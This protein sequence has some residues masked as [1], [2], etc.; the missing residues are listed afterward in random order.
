M[1]TKWWQKSVV[2]QQLPDGILHPQFSWFC[3]GTVVP[4]E[5]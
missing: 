5:V 3:S 1:E 4:R 2:Y